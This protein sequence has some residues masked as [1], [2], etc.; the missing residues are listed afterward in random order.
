[1]GRELEQTTVTFQKSF[2]IIWNQNHITVI[3]SNS[4]RTMHTLRNTVEYLFWPGKAE[5]DTVSRYM[6]KS[7][8]LGL[9]IRC[10]YRMSAEFLS[11]ESLPSLLDA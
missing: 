7:Q 10:S 9:G 1:M 11:L 2:R 8:V 6:L 4:L 3:A 5:L